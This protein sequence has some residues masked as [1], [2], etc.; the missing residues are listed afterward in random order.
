MRI[1]IVSQYFWPE[2]FRVN[3]LA[4]ALVSRGH[5][6]SVL[7]GLPNYPS[8]KLFEGYSWA[9]CGT[10]DYEGVAVFRVPLFVRRQGKS[11]QLALNFLSFVL[12]ACLL[13]PF[14]CRQRYDIIFVYEPSPF[15]VGIPGVLLRWLKNIPMV[16]W[17]Q[18][19]WPESLSATGAVRS[20]LLIGWVGKMVS[21]IYKRCDRV[22][23]QSRGFAEPAIAVGACPDRLRYFPN[24]AETIFQPV[25]VE[26]DTLESREMPPGFRIVFA[27]N[28]GAAQSLETVVEAANRLKDKIDIHWVILGDGRRETWLRG[29][30]TKYTLENT[31]HVLGRRPLE[32]MPRY[33]ALADVLLVTLR[34]DPI[35]SLTI[36]SKVQSYMACS[37]PLI[38]CLDGE[39]AEAVRISGG[40]LAGPAEDVDGLVA[41]VLKMYGLSAAEREEMG[42]K[43]RA[44]FEANFERE[45]LL[46]QLEDMME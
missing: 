30:I 8:G 38:A 28:L 6:V 34:R 32:S 15:T 19:L 18:D 35:F 21:F 29:E 33:F 3:D 17:V 26:N 22:L 14:F 25:E 7:T 39:A 5:D 9:S 43:G 4:L 23:I 11:W 12:S 27:G 46:D 2:S 41:M 44:Y 13:G 10:S 1:L 31:V 37:R 36:P 42:R 20:P 16:F 45:K 24:W 40:G